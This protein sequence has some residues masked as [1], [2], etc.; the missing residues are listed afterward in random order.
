MRV[1]F[2]QRPWDDKQ[3]YASRDDEPKGETIQARLRQVQPRGEVR[4]LAD[5]VEWVLGWGDENARATTAQKRA[6]TEDEQQLEACVGSVVAFAVQRDCLAR[7][8]PT[9]H[10]RPP[11]AE[12]TSD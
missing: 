9:V 4:A 8:H 2:L 5:L 10:Y 12:L 3:A 11:C 7:L 6:E 1:N